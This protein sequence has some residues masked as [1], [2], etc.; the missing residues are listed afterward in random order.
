MHQTP[1]VVAK[2]DDQVRLIR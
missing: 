1:G 2:R